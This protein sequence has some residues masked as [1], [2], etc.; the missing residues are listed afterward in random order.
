MSKPLQLRHLL[1]L[2]DKMEEVPRHVEEDGPVLPQE[3][4]VRKDVVYC[5]RHRDSADQRL[6]GP[7]GILVSRKRDGSLFFETTDDTSGTRNDTRSHLT[8][9]WWIPCPAHLTHPTPQGPGSPLS[10]SFSYA[11][12]CVS[13]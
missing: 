5:S 11:R 8:R 3:V 4:K 9:R 13:S 10:P 1:R 12:G 2:V 6:S 7:S